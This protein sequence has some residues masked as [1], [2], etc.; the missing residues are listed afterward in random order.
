MLCTYLGRVDTDRG[1][2]AVGLVTLDALDVDNE[3]LTVRLDDL[4]NGVALVVSSDN[5][6]AR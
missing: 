6:R 4:A 5:L 2:G 1:G 3:L